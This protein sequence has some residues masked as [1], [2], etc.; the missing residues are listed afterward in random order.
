MEFQ[1]FQ[2]FQEIQSFLQGISKRFQGGADPFAKS[3]TYPKVKLRQKRWAPDRISSLE[4]RIGSDAVRIRSDSVRFGSHVVRID[5]IGVTILGSL[6][7][8]FL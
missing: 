8:P 7:R 1:R 3:L 5:F 4:V 6:L 2:S